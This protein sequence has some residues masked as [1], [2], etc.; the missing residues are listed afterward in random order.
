MKKIFP[1]P[2]SVVFRQPP[3]LKKHLV[4]SS[5]KNY[6]FQMERMRRTDHRV[7]INTNM[8]GEVEDAY[9]AIH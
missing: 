6:R 8:G 2:P 5:L 9:S 4:R 1:R 7:V 3:N